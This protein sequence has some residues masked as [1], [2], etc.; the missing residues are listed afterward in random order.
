M[1]QYRTRHSIKFKA[2]VALVAMPEATRLWRSLQPNTGTTRPKSVAAK[3]TND[4][5]IRFCPQLLV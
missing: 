4:W 1:P 2:K 5:K 3:I